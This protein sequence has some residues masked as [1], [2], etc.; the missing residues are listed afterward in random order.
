M[1]MKNSEDMGEKSS[2]FKRNVRNLSKI[3]QKMIDKFLALAHSLPIFHAH[4]SDN[5]L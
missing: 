2:V 3:S 5:V 4:L 1:R